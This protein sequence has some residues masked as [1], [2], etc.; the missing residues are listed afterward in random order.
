MRQF[1]K[2]SKYAQE[3]FQ[4]GGESTIIF[5]N[6]APW[7]MPLSVQHMAWGEHGHY[8][9][10][11]VTLTSDLKFAD[12]IGH[13]STKTMILDPVNPHAAITSW[14]GTLTT[15]VGVVPPGQSTLTFDCLEEAAKPLRLT[16][17][18]M[19]GECD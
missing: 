7:V 14:H 19:C 11:K 9:K 5:D 6:K 2:P 1:I 18:V 3:I 17:I 12:R 4:D 16:S 13:D 8:P 15:F 10:T